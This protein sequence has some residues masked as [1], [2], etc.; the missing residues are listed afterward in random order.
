MS[1][2]SVLEHDVE[3]DV[4]IERGIIPFRGLPRAGGSIEIDDEGV[5]FLYRV[6][7]VSHP[8]NG[9]D[10]TIMVRK[11]GASANCRETLFS[12]IDDS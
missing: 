6:L 3:S 1:E 5:P 4:W 10:G 2:L 9:E 8:M 12:V 7:S 11:L